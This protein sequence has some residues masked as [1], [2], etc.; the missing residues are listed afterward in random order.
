MHPK[1]HLDRGEEEL[2]HHNFLTVT[3]DYMGFFFQCI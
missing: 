2:S 1:G 3:S